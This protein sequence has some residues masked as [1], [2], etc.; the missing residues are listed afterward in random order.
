MNRLRLKRQIAARLLLTVLVPMLIL[1][2]VHIH[3]AAF[4]EEVLCEACQQHV[5][6]Y[7]QVTATVFMLHDCVLCQFASLPFLAGFA[8]QALLVASAL[9]VTL[10]IPSV[11]LSL[12]TERGRKGRAPPRYF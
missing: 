1:A 10:R 7:D 8:V 9:S 2:S 11:T 5:T 12:Q 4:G 6:H 3:H